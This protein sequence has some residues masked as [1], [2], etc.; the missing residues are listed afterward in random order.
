LRFD[1]LASPSGHAQR[2]FIFR[3]L[4]SIGVASSNQILRLCK[5]RFLQILL[6]NSLYKRSRAN[7]Q[8]IFPLGGEIADVVCKMAPCEINVPELGAVFL[9]GEFFNK[10]CTSPP[11][12]TNAAKVGS[13]P[14]LHM[15]DMLCQGDPK[16]KNGLQAAVYLVCIKWWLFTCR[17]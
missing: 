15:F 1:S 13:P 12:V 8:K 9:V 14:T 3:W 7:H 11:L 6:K 16:V 4:R 5:I 2:V 17:A 10:I